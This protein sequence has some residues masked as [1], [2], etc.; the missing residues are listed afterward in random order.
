MI[1]TVVDFLFHGAS[2]PADIGA[3]VGERVDAELLDNL[4]G[5]A[6]LLEAIGVHQYLEV[7][8]LFGYLGYDVLQSVEMKLKCTYTYTF[9]TNN[10]YTKTRRSLDL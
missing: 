4:L 2:P 5:D 8:L 1:R 3:L 10:S 7:L 9:N 6:N